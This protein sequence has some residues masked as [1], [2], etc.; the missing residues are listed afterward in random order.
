MSFARNRARNFLDLPRVLVELDAQSLSQ[1]E[2]RFCNERADVV[3]VPDTSS[4]R[5]IP[6]ILHRLNACERFV[7][8]YTKPGSTGCAGQNNGIY[9]L[10]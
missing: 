6:I 7:E 4:G 8:F 1:G 5:I 2:C 10:E 3:N 9:K